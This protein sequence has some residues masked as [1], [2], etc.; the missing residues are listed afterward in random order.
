MIFSQLRVTCVRNE[1]HCFSFKFIDEQKTK[2]NKIK[3]YK[4]KQLK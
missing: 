4:N 2:S 3:K 1:M